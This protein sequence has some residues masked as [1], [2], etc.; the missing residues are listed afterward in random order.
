MSSYRIEGAV[1]ITGASSGIGAAFAERLARRGSP[2]I[3]VARDAD[4][5]N[6]LAARLRTETGQTVEVLT[7]DLG[8]ETQLSKVEHRLR[9]DKTIGG[10]I[11]NAGLGLLGD[12]AGTDPSRIAS[13][14]ALNVGAFTRLATAAAE[15]FLERRAGLIVNIG[16]V[17]ALA[18]ERA[19]PVYAGC[20]GYVLAFT[21]SLQQQIS[22][23]GVRVQAVLPGATRTEIFDRAGQSVNDIAPDRLMEVGDLVDAALAGLD[24]GERVTIPSLPDLADWEHLDQARRQLGPNLSRR[25]PAERYSIQ[26]A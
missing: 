4:R 11:N 5:L 14:L 23:Q 2:L 15:A 7:A 1:V 8:N 17:L 20:K 25:R 9:S 26:T 16:S 12:L 24:Q 3:L 18:P 10:L 6:T 19:H 21:Q 22:D 13:A